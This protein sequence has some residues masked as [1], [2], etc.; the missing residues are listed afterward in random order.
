LIIEVSR[1]VNGKIQSAST[2]QDLTE[3]MVSCTTAGQWPPTRQP[4]G[5]MSTPRHESRTVKTI[6]LKTGDGTLKCQT[7]ELRCA[8]DFSESQD[9]ENGFW[10]YEGLLPNAVTYNIFR[11]R[12][13]KAVGA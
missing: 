2:R 4:R 13:P 6:I 11:S 7:P 8:C 10:M 12:T 5:L 9:K 3:L 1:T